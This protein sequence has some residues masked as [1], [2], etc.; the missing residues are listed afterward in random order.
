MK[1]VYIAGTVGLPAC[2][3]GFET[4]VENL[5]NNANKDVKYTVFCSTPHYAKPLQEYG[6]A[7]LIYLPLNANGIQSIFYDIVSL[8]VTLF[9]KPDCLLLLGVSGCIFLPIFKLFSKT[10]VIVNIDGLEWRRQKWGR[11][12]KLFLKFSE[13][14]AVKFADEVISDNQAIGDYVFSEYGVHSSVIAYGGDH[15]I[16]QRQHG[17]EKGYA[18]ALCRIEPENNVDLILEAFSKLTTPLY[19]VGNW[20]NSEYGLNLK[21][22]FSGFDN[23]FLIDQVYD[24]NALFELRD[25]CSIYLHGHSAGGTNPSLVEMMFFSK[26]ILA[27]DCSFNRY[28]TNNKA[29]YFNSS[30][31][32]IDAI[33]RWK[34]GAL[35]PTCGKSMRALAD[36]RYTWDVITKAY[37]QLYR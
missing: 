36:D 23:I 37:E 12:A 29:C 20:K 17:N 26:P 13:R 1:E 16:S 28:T 15:A 2:Y 22:H 21:K 31:S 9:R 30:A 18:L 25:G 34:S 27:F 7:K 8:I 19:F 32:L 14:M 3:G 6:G 5:V 33:G 24:P 4:L 10:K 35:L 11:L